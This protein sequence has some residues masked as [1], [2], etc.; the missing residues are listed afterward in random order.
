M[1]QDLTPPPKTMT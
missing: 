1:S